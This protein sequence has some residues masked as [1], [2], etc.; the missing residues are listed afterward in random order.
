[1]G[2]IGKC[3]VRGMY[4]LGAPRLWEV[5]V[6]VSEIGYVL[7]WD[8]PLNECAVYSDT[9]RVGGAT[10]WKSRASASV[11]NEA[12]SMAAQCKHSL[13]TGA[14]GLAPSS[15]IILPALRA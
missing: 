15:S 9:E 8:V 10:R 5:P 1:M 7:E 14:E 3:G 6:Q 4:V 13:C 11:M 12:F 2:F